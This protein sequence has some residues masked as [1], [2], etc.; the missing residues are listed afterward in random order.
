MLRTL[1]RLSPLLALLFFCSCDPA[2][3]GDSN[4]QTD[5]EST[6]AFAASHDQDTARY[7][8][9][10]IFKVPPAEQLGESATDLGRYGTVIRPETNRAE[11]QVLLKNTWVMEFYVDTDAS[12]PQ[13]M[14]GTGQWL[15]F[16]ADGTFRGGHWDRET[17][18]GAYY[19]D[20]QGRY[21]KLTL[22]SNVDAMDAIWEIQAINGE[23]DAMSW[24]RTNETKFGPYRRS[25]LVKLIELYDLPTK[26]QFARQWKKSQGID[27]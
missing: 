18:R 22:D 3:T 7:R 23:Q 4:Q 19:L 2:Q 20:Y 10:Y 17:H 26:E 24:R 9:L 13:R 5:Y 8:P 16:N 15:Q 12:L 6:A 14:A 11:V 25:V 21:P 27:S 1:A